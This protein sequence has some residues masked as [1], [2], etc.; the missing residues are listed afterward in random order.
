MGHSSTSCYKVLNFEQAETVFDKIKPPRSIHAVWTDTVRPL[1]WGTNRTSYTCYRIEKNTRDGLT[2]YDIMLYSTIIA[3]YHK[4]V[5]GASTVFYNYYR[6]NMTRDFLF[7]VLNRAWNTTVTTT[8]GR[9]VISPIGFSYSKHHIV[10]P[11]DNSPFAM[12]CVFVDGKLDTALSHHTKFYTKVRTDADKQLRA[13]I[14]KRVESIVDLACMRLSTMEQ[15][16]ELS[17]QAGRPFGGGRYDKYEYAD[18]CGLVDPDVLLDDAMTQDALNAFFVSAQDVYNI[19]VSKRMYAEGGNYLSYRDNDPTKLRRPV[20][21]GDFR[22]S[23]MRF[24]LNQSKAGKRNGKKYL[25]MWANPN[26]WPSTGVY[27]E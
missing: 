18:W 3:R 26:E 21:E 27:A 8:D 23:L 5:G 10:D 16:A 17:Y 14:R 25:P 1:K 13:A 20:T 11:V 15:A 24:I 12:R 19:L 4:P 9:K 6:S 2:Y 7:C 22:T